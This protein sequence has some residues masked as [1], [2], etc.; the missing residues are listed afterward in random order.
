MPCFKFWTSVNGKTVVTLRKSLVFGLH[1][2]L[3]KTQM[4]SQTSSLE[5]RPRQRKPAKVSSKGKLTL[6]QRSLVK[7]NV[8]GWKR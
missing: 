3:P 8:A 2:L 5:F 6:E 7:S 4:E 1:S